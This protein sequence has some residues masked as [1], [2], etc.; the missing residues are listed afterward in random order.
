LW[1]GFD[2]DEM[3]MFILFLSM[4]HTY[5]SKDCPAYASAKATHLTIMKNHVCRNESSTEQHI[6]NMSAFITM[7]TGLSYAAIGDLI[8]MAM[9]HGR[10]FWTLEDYEHYQN[11][12]EA[13]QPRVSYRNTSRSRRATIASDD[14]TFTTEGAVVADLESVAS[15][16][17][18]E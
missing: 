8:S 10:T 17:E 15:G 4:I 16:D 2:H 12:R 18:D 11:L 6:A 5:S 13:F 14:C 3:G 7:L 9:S 1:H